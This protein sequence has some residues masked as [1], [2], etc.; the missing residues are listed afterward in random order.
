MSERGKK[1]LAFWLAA[2]YQRITFPEALAQRLRPVEKAFKKAGESSPEALLGIYVDYSPKAELTSEAEP[3]E[4]DVVVVYDSS[5]EG[6]PQEAVSAASTIQ[7]AFEKCYKVLDNAAG[8]QWCKIELRSCVPASDVQFTL[9]DV[10]TYSMYR[11][12]HISLK[13]DPASSVPHSS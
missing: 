5:I 7:N 8:R 2:R 12:E 10:M 9:Q 1:T 6:A 13:Q 3:Y 11:L 4:F